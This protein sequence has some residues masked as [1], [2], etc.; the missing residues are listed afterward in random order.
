MTV[1]R[2]ETSRGPRI[3]LPLGGEEIWVSVE[4]AEQLRGELGVALGGSRCVE[5][6]RLRAECND[7][8]DRDAEVY[9]L[10]H[11]LTALVHRVERTGGYASMEEQDV[12][13]AARGEVGYGVLFAY[14]PSD[15]GFEVLHTFAS[16]PRAADGEFPMGALAVDASGDVYGTAKGGGL[17]GSG[18]VFDPL[19]AHGNDN[20]PIQEPAVLHDGTVIA[21]R[22]FGGAAG[23][24][25]VVQLDPRAGITPLWQA[26]DI[27]LEAAP[28]FSN[29]TGGIL[30][31]RLAEGRDGMLYGV[32]QYGGAAG[33]G[34]I[35][36][37]ARDGSLF[38]L[39]RSWSDAAYPYGGV[40]V[41]SDGAV[42]GTTFN[43]S[44]VWRLRLR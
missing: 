41:G 42:Y 36:R 37:I 26:Q 9:R 13:R 25:V 27:P 21:V 16:E 7:A 38:Q 8:S 43:T 35:Y 22:E 29:A 15:G 30:N 24:G 20:T 32:A 31:G 5:C 40:T 12:L 17:S 3:V 18:T 28:R 6:D 19:P 2:E 39:L 10:R 23:T 14:S 34:G 44:E 1:R 33:A 4:R 11:A